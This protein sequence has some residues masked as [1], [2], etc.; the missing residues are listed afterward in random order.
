M[1]NDN[2]DFLTGLRFAG[3]CSLLIRHE[4]VRKRNLKNYPNH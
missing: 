2:V 3:T 1:I 4:M